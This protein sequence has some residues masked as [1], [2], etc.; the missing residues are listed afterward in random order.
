MAHYPASVTL[1]RLGQTRCCEHARSFPDPFNPPP[2]WALLSSDLHFIYL[3]PLLASHLAEQAESLVGKSLLAF[4]HPE[5]QASAKS[6]LGGVLQS[7][8]LH[9]SVT[10]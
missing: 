1:P 3:D 2:D 4:V 7:K 6:D 9:G 5:E 8:H 10:R